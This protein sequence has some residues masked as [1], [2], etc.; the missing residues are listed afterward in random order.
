MREA[1]RQGGKAAGRGI[2]ALLGFGLA[3]AGCGKAR[4]AASQAD[5]AA[6]GAAAANAGDPLA[7]LESGIKI[8]TVAPAVSIGDL[9]GNPVD[10]GAYIGKKPVLIEFWA[11]WCSKCMA[12]LPQLDQLHAKYGDRLAL[13]G[14]NVTVNDS[15]E[16][17]RRYLEAHKPPYIALFD[18]KGVGARAFEV[19]GTSFIMMVD[20]TGKVAYTGVGEDQNLLAAAEKVMGAAP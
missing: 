19:P 7:E 5:S 18:D 11:T 20:A 10:L 17:V 14:V 4:T 13:I 12:L 1:R 3:V 9:D 6:V 8:G 16:R 15:K 2:V